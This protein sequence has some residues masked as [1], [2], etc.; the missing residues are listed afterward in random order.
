[1]PVKKRT[2]A[3]R[4][5]VA[6]ERSLMILPLLATDLSRADRKALMEKT[7]RDNG[8]S[9]R[10]LQRYL[11]KYRKENI[12][13]LKPKATKDRARKAISDEVLSKAIEL[14]LELPS[15]SVKDIIYIM[16]TNSVIARGEVKRP[17]LQ[18]YLQE[19]GYG[20][21]QMKRYVPSMGQNAARR[22]QMSHRMKLVQADIKYG[23]YIYMNGRKTTRVYWIG[24]IDDYSRFVLGGKFYETQEE[25]NVVDSLQD[26]IRK[27][28]IMDALLCDNG[29]Q[30]IGKHLHAMC[31]N[32][33]I[34]IKHLVPLNA[35]GKGKIER[36]NREVDHFSQECNLMK[37]GSLEEINAYFITWL[38]K[39]HQDSPHSSLE[40]GKS[41]R[42]VFDEDVTH[43]L[44]HVPEE[45]IREAPYVEELR[46]VRNGCVSVDGIKFEV[47]DSG[48]DGRPVT[49]RWGCRKPDEVTVRKDGFSS[50]TAKRQVITEHVDY[51]RRITAAAELE[52]R[53][54][55]SSGSSLLQAQRRDFES[56]HPDSQRFSQ[57]RPVSETAD[58]V[59][60]GTTSVIKF[61][62]IGK[63]ENT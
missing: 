11:K 12:E 39:K 3:A 41:P 7:A 13:G 57:A 37:C 22:F 51:K 54:A 56:E 31:R 55:A 61:S 36:L 63:E 62:V 33:G 53:R 32:L 42:T 26:V 14:R 21:S 48:L 35:A 50:V 59:K 28:G 4:S 9:V 45:L 34:R 16:E 5:R 49:V 24:W 10:T 38:E 25:K 20:L 30:Y 1:M 15:R 2:E 8:L 40:E 29:S 18:N 46:T 19:A 58:T 47:P 27:Y 52:R 23:P 60:D 43:P 44:V 17:T 6:M